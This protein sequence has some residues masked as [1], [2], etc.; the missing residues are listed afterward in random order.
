MSNRRN[1]SRRKNTSAIPEPLLAGNS[2]GG[3]VLN[4][5]TPT[6]I[7]D[8]PSKGLLYPSDH[9]LYGKDTVEIRHMTAKEEDILSSQSLLR[10][11]VAIDRML[12]SILIDDV[13]V[14][15]L[16]IGDRNALLYAARVTGYGSDYEVE[17]ECDNCDRDYDFTFDLST[18]SDSYTTMET[19]KG[20]AH[21]FTENG[22]VELEL[23]KSKFLVEIRA[24]TGEDET[25]LEKAREMK[26]TNNLQE[27]S[28]TDMIKMMLHSANGVTDREQLNN[29]ADVMPALDSRLIRETYRKVM[30]N[31]AFKQQTECTHCGYTVEMEVPIT[32][33][34]FWPG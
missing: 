23:P 30:P 9:P 28:L 22:T 20:D 8:L 3:S 26:E 15:E 32:G 2:S 4:F 10:K 25:K 13:N 14:E 18:Y 24:L 16:T 11:G 1:E 7:V 5:S 21:R 17:I 29:F 19:K 12:Q 6:E 31:V 27:S 34:F 33:D